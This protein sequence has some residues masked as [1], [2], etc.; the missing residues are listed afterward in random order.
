[1][2]AITWANAIITALGVPTIGAALVFIGKKLQ[3]LSDVQK[4]MDKMKSNIKVIGDHLIKNSDEFNHSELQTYSPFRL[5]PEG[6]KL[7]GQL[8][9]DTILAQHTTDF[10]DCIEQELPTKKY[11]VETAAIKSIFLLLDKQYMGALKTFFYNNP[12]RNLQNTAPTLG[13]YLRDIYLGAHPEI[14]E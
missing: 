10:F 3:V 6:K 8:H 4:T 13:V 2:N 14:K 11:D 1:M 9:F 7:V 5:T 12:A